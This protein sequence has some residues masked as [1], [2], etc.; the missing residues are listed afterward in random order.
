VNGAI[1]RKHNRDKAGRVTMFLACLPRR[2]RGLLTLWGNVHQKIALF[3]A[4]VSAMGRL[5]CTFSRTLSIT[6]RSAFWW[7][8]C[9][10]PG[11][12]LCTKLDNILGRPNALNGSRRRET[13]GGHFQAIFHPE[14]ARLVCK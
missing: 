11:Q 10:W 3:R 7:H 1:S 5:S 9:F 12:G 8:A 4:N 14:K 6:S 13:A 2:W